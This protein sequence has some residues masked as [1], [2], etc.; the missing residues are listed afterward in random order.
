LSDKYGRKPVIVWSMLAC[1]PLLYMALSTQG[2]LAWALT[3]VAGMAM[4]ASF[5]PAILIAQDLIPKNQGM[6][7]GIILGLAM[8]IGGLGIA[9][10]GAIADSAGITA[11]TFSLVI[12]PFIGFLLALTLPGALLPHKRSEL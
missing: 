8:G 5:S 4:L 3:A 11:G 6:A 2:Y 1:A 9:L 7:S 10:T 12:L